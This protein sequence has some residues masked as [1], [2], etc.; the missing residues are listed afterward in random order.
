[1]ATK[2]EYEAVLSSSELDLI[3]G[4]DPDVNPNDDPWVQLRELVT[5]VNTVQSIV[6]DAVVAW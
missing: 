5:Y 2:D 4:F 6:D 3:L 1:M